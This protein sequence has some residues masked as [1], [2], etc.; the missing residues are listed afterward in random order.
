[1]GHERRAEQ[2]Q[3]QSGDIEDVDWGAAFAWLGE[4]EKD[5]EHEGGEAELRSVDQ[6]EMHV[7]VDVFC[8][9][10]ERDWD[11]LHGPAIVGSEPG[12]DLGV[13]VEVGC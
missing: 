5:E 9:I 4:E 6:S 11:F 10:W 13:W 3:D 7:L 1:M 8:E 12:H 2:I